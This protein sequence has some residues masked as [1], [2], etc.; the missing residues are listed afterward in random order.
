MTATC[1]GAVL[2]SAYYETNEQLLLLFYCLQSRLMIQYTFTMNSAIN[3]L[4]REIWFVNEVR[5][6][7]IMFTSVAYHA[8]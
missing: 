2:V 6:I 8:C 5:M 4:T 1:L 7:N 3:G